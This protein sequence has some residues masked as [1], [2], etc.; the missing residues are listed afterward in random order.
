MF[1]WTHE[2]LHQGSLGRTRERARGE[3]GTELWG[4]GGDQGA[5]KTERGGEESALRG[6]INPDSTVTLWVTLVALPETD[7]QRPVKIG[8]RESQLVNYGK[9]SSL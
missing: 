6:H 8:A 3:S 4:N 7:A 1:R 9:P 5:V 2:A